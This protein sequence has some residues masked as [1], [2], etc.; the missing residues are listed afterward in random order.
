VTIKQ[1]KVFSPGSIAN[2]GPGFD[3]FAIALENM[4]DYV[5]L[6]TISEAK[7]IID[8]SGIGA[9]MIPIDNSRN[10]A[11]AILEYIKRVKGINH[12]FKV[13]IQK[14]VP[15]GKG[16]GSSGSSAA[17]TAFAINQLLELGMSEEELVRLA[18]IGESAIAGS[19]HA[20]N[21][22]ASLFGG[23]VMVDQ[24]FKVVRLDA[25]DIGIVVVAPHFNIENKT[26]AARELLPDKVYLKDAV[27]NIGNAS[28]MAVAVAINDPVL[29]GSS[30]SDH[31]IEPYR[32]K[33]I[34]HFWEVKEAAL[35]AGAYGCSIAG[36]GPS[37]FAMGD[38][39]ES[40]GEAM[41]AAFQDV[42]SNLYFTRPSNLGVREV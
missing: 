30:I 39:L 18:S 14:G 3:V 9:E 35:K 19:P 24:D 25:I 37:V 42:D 29:F 23:F 7:I 27:Y 34:P 2:L 41:V 8:I 32:A 16:L 12:G 21:V 38:D 1:I 6:N 36:G 31:V 11:G 26:K 10:S 40:I 22:S 17:G 28:K 5:T 33:M 20:D 15:P 13:D 4:G